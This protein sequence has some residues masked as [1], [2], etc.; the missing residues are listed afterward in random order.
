[1]NEDFWKTVES[2]ASDSNKP[3]RTGV[4]N[5]A[6]LFGTAV[7]ALSLIV[8]PMIA[9]KSSARVAQYPDNFDMIS[10]G[11]IN[12][13]DMGKSYSIRRSVIQPMPTMPCVVKSYGDDGAC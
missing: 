6:L 13:T 1:M 5:V 4:L 3:H 8:T 9:G 11:S 12:K 7:I 10:T 2:R